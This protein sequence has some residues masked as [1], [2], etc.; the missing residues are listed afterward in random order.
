MLIAVGSG[1]TAWRTVRLCRSSTRFI[2]PR[3][4][5]VSA[6]DDSCIISRSSSRLPKRWPVK[7]LPPRQRNNTPETDS[8]PQCLLQNPNQPAQNDEI[9]HCVSH[10]NRPQE[11]LGVL[12]EFMK[13][14]GRTPPG[15]HLLAD[16]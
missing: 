12:Q 3:S 2:I 5:E 11:I 15:A 16:P 13:H 6:W 14:F 4:S 10:K 8:T 7:T 1:V 9:R